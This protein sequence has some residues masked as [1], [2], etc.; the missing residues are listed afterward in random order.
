M[1]LEGPTWKTDTLH[2]SHAGCTF[3]AC[4]YA[5]LYVADEMTSLAAS[6][7]WK[8]PGRKRPA[9]HFEKLKFKS[10]ATDHVLT[11]WLSPTGTIEYW[12]KL[13]NDGRKL[14]KGLSIYDVHMKDQGVRPRWTHVDGGVSSMWTFT[15]KI[16]T[17]WH[18]PV[19]F[20]CEEVGIFYQHFVFGRTKKWKFFVCI[21]KLYVISCVLPAMILS[22]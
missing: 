19:L 17:L 13:Q 20:S 5:Y 8:K 14:Y 1:N 10:L 21:C 7:F 16:R 22:K 6:Q 11:I 15:R 2:M 4:Q 3:M 18:H 12:T 9:S